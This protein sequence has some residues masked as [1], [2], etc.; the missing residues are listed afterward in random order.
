V[1]AHG[2]GRLLRVSRLSQLLDTLSIVSAEDDFL[3]LRAASILRMF[4]IVHTFAVVR[5]RHPIIPVL[6]AY[7]TVLWRISEA[8]LMS[9]RGS[10]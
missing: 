6:G 7:L 9:P 10:F 2:D 4:V 1:C 8:I 5:F 3:L